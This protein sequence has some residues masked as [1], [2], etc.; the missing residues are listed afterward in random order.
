MRKWESLAETE[1]QQNKEAVFEH[2]TMIRQVDD[3]MA[4]CCKLSE[5]RQIK[6]AVRNS[7]KGA[8]AAAGGAF[9]GGLLGGPPGLFIGSSLGGAV[10]WWMTSGTFRPL[11][12]II[13]EMPPQQKMKLYSEVMAVLGKL[14]WVDLA[15]LIFLVMGN[16]SLQMR[17]LTTLISFATKELGAKVE[18][19]QK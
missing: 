12:Q 18:Y 19:E 15:Q 8:A 13:I 16:S 5:S 6:A 9:V 11:H 7:A 2:D 17:V 10:G 3:V 14:D 4:L 1:S